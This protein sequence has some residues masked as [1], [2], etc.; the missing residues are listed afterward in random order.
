MKELRC[1]ECGGLDPI[2]EAQDGLIYGLDVPTLPEAVTQ[3]RE[4]EGLVYRHKIG[5]ELTTSVGVPLAV[6]AL[7]DAASHTEIMLDLKLND[8]P[9]TMKGAM[10]AVARLGVWGVTVMT[11]VGLDSLKAAVDHSG[12]TRVIGVTILTSIDAAMCKRVYGVNPLT[13]TLLLCEMLVEA[14]A[15]HVVCS[16]LEVGEIMKRGF[17]LIPITPGI[18]TEK[19]GGKDQKRTMLPE[20]AVR[21][22]NGGG[23]IVVSRAIREADDRRAAAKT[24]LARMASAY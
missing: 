19:G 24:I 18:V 23:H 14:G 4:L 13:A 9:N 16:P 3:I 11:S 15:T 20:E 2:A 8:I 10:K 12:D 21:A 1:S 22:Q 6:N 5:L 17:D 7:K